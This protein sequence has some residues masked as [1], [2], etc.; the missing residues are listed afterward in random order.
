MK[1]NNVPI[2]KRILENAGP[3]HSAIIT[4]MNVTLDQR[5]SE[6]PTDPNIHIQRAERSLSHAGTLGSRVV[7]E[8][9]MNSIY[10]K[11]EIN[12]D[13][14]IIVA[15]YELDKYGKKQYNSSSVG[16]ISR[17]AHNSGQIVLLNDYLKEENLL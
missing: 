9:A 1:S 7:L 14:L 12:P 2:D 8:R 4:L 17:K 16:F 5:P 10:K 11:L 3:L 6:N 13:Q 15:V